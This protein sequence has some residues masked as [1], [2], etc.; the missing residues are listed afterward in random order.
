MINL[1]PLTIYPQ[2]IALLIAIV[3]SSYLFW[4]EGVKKK[5]EEEALLDFVLAALIGGLV[6]GRLFYFLFE[7][8]LTVRNFLQLLK[9]WQGG[10]RLWYGALTGG[11]IAGSLFA[12]R[13]R[14]DLLKIWDAAVPAVILGQ[15]FGSLPVY[16][17]ESLFL[18]VFFLL[19]NH[20]RREELARG[21]H[22][23][24]Y[25]VATSLLRFLAEFFRFEKTL[26]FGVNLNQILSF[27]FFLSGVLG[28]KWVYDRSKRNFEMDIKKLA[29][30]VKLPRIPLE[31]IKKQ[32]TRENEKLERQQQELAEENPLFDPGR[33]ESNPELVAEAEE[34]ISHRRFE[35]V[36][37][38]VVSRAK[39][40]QRALS[41]MKK[42]KYGTCEEC[43]EQIDPARLEADPSVTLC[44]QCQE[45]KELTQ[46][47]Q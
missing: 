21:F 35:A 45:K 14:W 4:R 26:L 29:K 37:E 47:T 46:V 8:N 23:A 7:Q 11:L 28:M 30:R 43:G 19:F 13:N 9:F 18:L 22:L 24:A 1:G 44:L 12:D 20:I 10:G 31:T 36:R 17:W 33:T 6:G 27:A 5:F 32:L 3:G 38:A 39:Q 40:V 34:E 16:P 25:L 41:H 15:A 2:G 42:G